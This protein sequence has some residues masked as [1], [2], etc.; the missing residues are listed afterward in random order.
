MRR[1]SQLPLQTQILMVGLAQI[2][3]QRGI[4]EFSVELVD[5]GYLSHQLG[6]ITLRKT[7]HHIELPDLAA[8]F[9]L[10]TRKN[11]IYRL[12]FGI[13]DKSACIDDHDFAFHFGGIVMHIITGF[14]ELTHEKLR[15]DQIF[16]TTEGNNVD[17][18]LDHTL[19]NCLRT[20]NRQIHGGGKAANLLF[21]HPNRYI[22]QV[23]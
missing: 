8:G 12:F 21:L 14:A 6:H 10:Y 23:S 11:H 16:G 22:S 7:S 3:Q 19:I 17:T 1:G 9:R 2:S 20:T 4:I 13:A 5:L 18:V 15:V